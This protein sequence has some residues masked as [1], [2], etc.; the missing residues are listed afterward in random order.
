MQVKEDIVKAHNSKSA[1][2]PEGERMKQDNVWLL[3]KVERLLNENY[4]L[5]SRL[6]GND[7]NEACEEVRKEISQKPNWRL[8]ILQTLW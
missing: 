6:I 2:Q 4:A 1:Q 3:D 7:L 8:L 5:R